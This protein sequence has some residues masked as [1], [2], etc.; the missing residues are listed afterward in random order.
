MSGE[1]HHI[2]R[3]SNSILSSVISFGSGSSVSPLF[4]L[5]A[6]GQAAASTAQGIS[7]QPQAERDNENSSDTVNPTC[8]PFVKQVQ[9]NPVYGPLVHAVSEYEIRLVHGK[10]QL[11]WFLLVKMF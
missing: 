2:I 1:Q 4:S 3:P 8:T 7:L 9:T 10:K 11:H 6:T 5:Q